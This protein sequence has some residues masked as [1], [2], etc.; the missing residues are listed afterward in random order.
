MNIPQ[1]TLN[2][3]CEVTVCEGTDTVELH[4]KIMKGTEY[5]V[6]F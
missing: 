2:V 5:F 6:T 3:F 1:W 4:Y